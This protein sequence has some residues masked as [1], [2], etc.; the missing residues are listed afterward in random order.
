MGW[1]KGEPIADFW[2][3]QENQTKVVIGESRGCGEISSLGWSN[4]NR[5]EVVRLEGERRGSRPVVGL[6]SRGTHIAQL[7]AKGG[8]QN[9]PDLWF[10]VGLSQSIVEKQGRLPTKTYLVTLLEAGNSESPD[11]CAEFSEFPMFLPT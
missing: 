3:L 10:A 7:S 11:I 5:R 8:R 4:G 1:F 2:R 9:P 6:L